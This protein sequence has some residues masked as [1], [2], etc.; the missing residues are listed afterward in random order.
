MAN[1]NETQE[2]KGAELVS[3]PPLASTIRT[4]V[5]MDPDHGG[6]IYTRLEYMSEIEQAGYVPNIIKGLVARLEETRPDYVSLLH[7]QISE[8]TTPSPTADTEE[9]DAQEDLQPTPEL[10]AAA[11]EQ[12]SPEEP[13]AA[14]RYNAELAA[15]LVL[16][17]SAHEFAGAIMTAS[18]F[19]QQTK[20]PSDKKIKHQLKLAQNIYTD[21]PLVK[22]SREAARILSE[23]DL[24]RLGKFT[25]GAAVAVVEYSGLYETTHQE[26]PPGDK[27]DAAA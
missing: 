12:S 15:R 17:T 24:D 18:M 26:T 19:N 25:V 6:P 1:A 21:D 16:A 14:D 2:P 5:G 3:L 20:Q 27:P 4:F 22:L 10:D 11:K 8:R 23:D 13:S 9:F 7:Q